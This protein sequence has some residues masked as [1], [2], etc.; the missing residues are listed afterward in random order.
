MEMSDE[1]R[2]QFD[3]LLNAVLSAG[4]AEHPSKAGYAE[5]RAAL[6]AYVRDLERRAATDPRLE[7]A[8]A[9]L[10]R[11]DIGEGEGARGLVRPYTLTDARA[12]ARRAREL[13]RAALGVRVDGR[14]EQ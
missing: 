9:I 12:Q 6:F 2:T 8:E 3:Y 11:M 1:K 14:D 4:H 13:I 7:E 10:R 5:K